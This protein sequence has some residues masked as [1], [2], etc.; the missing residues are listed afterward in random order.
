[1][2]HSRRRI[3][4]SAVYGIGA[5]LSGAVINAQGQAKTVAKER[6]IKIQAKKFVYTPNQIVL[7]K[8]EPVVLEFTSV[9][10]VHGFKIPDMNIRADLPPGKVTQVRLTPDKAGEY[11]FL[12]D[13]FCGSGH[14][15]MSGKITVI[16]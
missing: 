16:D 2:D 1:M 11:D 7:K 6:V 13:N 10:F 3:C 15:E 9:D 8:G 4:L 12:C 14:E 5:L